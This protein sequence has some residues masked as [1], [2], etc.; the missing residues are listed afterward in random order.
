MSHRAVFLD[1]GTV[2]N[3]DLDPAPLERVLPGIVLYERS[4]QAEVPAITRKKPCGLRNESAVRKNT[5][6][7]LP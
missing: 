7:T 3:G 1:F 5:P 4:A 6:P 2:S